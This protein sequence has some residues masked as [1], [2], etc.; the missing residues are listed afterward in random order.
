[1][2][3]SS[4]TDATYFLVIHRAAQSELEQAPQTTRNALRRTLKDVAT[5][6]RPTNHSKAKPLR[7]AENLFRVREG[8]YRALCD[9][10]LPHVRVLLVDH[11]G[12]VYSRTEEAIE[13]KRA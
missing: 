3:T 13:R 8:K 5:C 11:R 12:D 2:A 10:S 9:L 4:T 6:E 7:H 1:M